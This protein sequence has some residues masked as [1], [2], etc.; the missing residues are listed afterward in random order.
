MSDHAHHSPTL[1]EPDQ[2]SARGAGI[3]LATLAIVLA[4][5]SYLLYVYFLRETELVKYSQ[6][7]SQKNAALHDVRAYEVE[8]LSTYG[9]VDA[10][11]GIYRVPANKGTELFLREAAER[12]AANLPQRIQPIAAAK[13]EAA[14]DEAQEVQAQ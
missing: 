13:E 12:Q 9:V 7:L 8:L 3:A 6:V 10:A 11:A 1:A 2:T 5:T 4:I 14:T